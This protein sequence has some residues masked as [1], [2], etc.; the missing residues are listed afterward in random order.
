VNWPTEQRTVHCGEK[1]AGKG[2]N[3]EVGIK[4]EK[5]A[6]GG[7]RVIRDKQSEL[8]SGHQTDG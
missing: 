5:D 6:E 1:L 3:K 8:E 4:L 2:E 7:P